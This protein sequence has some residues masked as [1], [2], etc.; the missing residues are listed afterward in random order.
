MDAEEAQLRFALLAAAP[1]GRRDFS[2]QAMQQAVLTIPGV[3]ANDFS[4]CRFAPESFLI[5]FSTQRSRDAALDAKSV[6][7]GS[8]QLL[9]RP[10]TRLVRA[11]HRPLRQ[12]VRLEIE[13]V[14]AHAWSMRVARKLL[15][16]SCWIEHLELSTA[17]RSD[18]SFMALTA[19]TDNPSMIPKRK[20]LIIAEHERQ[21]VHEDP[22]VE[23]IFANTRP[24]L[25][26]KNTLQYEVLIHLR[27]IADFSPRSPSPSPGPSPPSSNGDSG[28]DG[29]P[30]R[31]YGESRGDGGPRLHGFP[32]V[33]GRADGEEGTSG[34]RGA[35]GGRGSGSRR[36]SSSLPAR[37]TSAP[38][39][40]AESSGPAGQAAKAGPPAQH[41][42]S[43]DV[44][45]A[46]CREGPPEPPAASLGQAAAAEETRGNN[47]FP[48]SAT[49]KP[50][51]SEAIP[52]ELIPFESQ[53]PPR[54]ATTVKSQDP[55]L[56]EFRATRLASQLDKLPNAARTG[57]RTYKRRPRNDAATAPA[58]AA[59]QAEPDSTTTAELDE[60]AY[61]E[62][63]DQGCDVCEPSRAAAT[64]SR[65]G[66]IASPGPRAGKR[67]R[68][69][70]RVSEQPEATPSKQARLD[71]ELE[72]E[73]AK[74]A[75]AAFLASVSRALQVPL[76]TLPT[77][78]PPTSPSTALRRSTRLAAKPLNSSVRA[79]KKGEVLV[80]R[81]LGICMNDDDS[82]QRQQ[83]A[84]VFRGPLDTSH[85]ASL[86]D[87]FPAA[88]ALSDAELH[89]AAMQASQAV[90]AC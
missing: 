82:G 71:E 6:C 56:F 52:G 34:S 17:D 39:S 48:Q 78:P 74:A 64:P 51:A 35:S 23:C 76:A 75:T 69:G 9:F 8:A 11:S 13:G 20:R 38:A 7:V 36:R 24:Y 44:Q 73:Q 59:L 46:L 19:W 58:E 32:P 43:D 1:D 62:L 18:M 80:M 55:M 31:G 70:P 89:A 37:K 85:Y 90:C 72:I 53:V 87:I 60:P 49:D 47:T 68:A 84:E 77:R 12:R 30:D 63:A 54:A 3:R 15:A 41:T 83:L 65:N 14:P 67:N 10:W 79:S 26:E 81:K 2:V 57:L 28:H 29:N 25:R 33:Y 22:E 86:R 16:S 66:P 21:V 27:N 88:R 50:A 40:R 4:I 5:I 61:F 42:S 45:K